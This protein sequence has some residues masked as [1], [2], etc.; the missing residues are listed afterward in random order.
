MAIR[1][2]PSRKWWGPE[3]RIKK[4][5]QEGDYVSIILSVV[6]WFYERKHNFTQTHLSQEDSFSLDDCI[7]LAEREESK[8]VWSGTTYQ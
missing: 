3:G 5:E 8:P 6:I 1:K 7:W 4:E 2:L